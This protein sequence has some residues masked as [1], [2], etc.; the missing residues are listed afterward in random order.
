[1]ILSVSRRTDIPNYYSD[2]FF[3]RI[4]EGFFYVRNPVNPHQISKVTLSPELVDCIV[5]WT[6]N[7]EPMFDRLSELDGYAYYFQ[8]TLTGYGRDIEPGVPHKKERMIP[9]F[10][11]LSDRIGS[12]RVVWRYDP[13]LFNDTYTPD[14]HLRAFEQIA[15]ALSGYTKRCVI[16]FVDEYARNRAAMKALGVRDID[17]FGRKDPEPADRPVMGG[18]KSYNENEISHNSLKEFAA[19]ISSIARRNGMEIHTCAEKTDLAD[20][21]IRHGS[22]IDRTLIEEIIGCTIKAEQD[23]NQRAECGCVESVEVGTYHTCPN[24][25]RYCYANDSR[26]KAEK[27]HRVYD[28]SSPILCSRIEDGDKITERKVVSLKDGQIRIFSD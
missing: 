3:N 11:K 13:I 9:V 15:S 14:C 4:K 19:E 22:C 24:G 10:Q 17:S 26:E 2:W 28:A 16:S 18:Q 20:C 1:M 6:K 23:R 7:P 21:G 8:F 12:H 25:C 27:N 5:F